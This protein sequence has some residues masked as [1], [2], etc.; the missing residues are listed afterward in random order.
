MSVRI[1]LYEF[2]AYTIPGVFYLLIAGFAASIFGLLPITWSTVNDLSLTS[3]IILTGAGYVCGYLMDFFAYRLARPFRPKATVEATLQS[4]EKQHPWIRK[5]FTY[6]DWGIL[7]HMLKQLPNDSVA[8]LEQ[9]NATSMMMRNIG[10]GFL[11]LALVFILY[12]ILVSNALGNVVMALISLAFLAVALQVSKKFREWYYFGIYEAVAAQQFSGI[13]W[14]ED[15]RE[16][17]LEDAEKPVKA[18]EV[19]QQSP[20]SE[21]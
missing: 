21:A 12:F 9:L 11:L 8:N 13:R 15:Q 1:G 20:D 7:T 14:M 5:N 18:I 6:S 3:L 17:K 19:S 16:A 10:F 4:F 2:F